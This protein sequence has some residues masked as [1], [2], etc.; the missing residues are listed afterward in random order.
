MTSLILFPPKLISVH[1][2]ETV[3]FFSDIFELFEEMSQGL[4]LYHWA[5]A[6]GRET[7]SASRARAF[8]LPAADSFALLNRSI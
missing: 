7:G 1:A 8:Y 6:K 4:K 3:A 5:K 2:A